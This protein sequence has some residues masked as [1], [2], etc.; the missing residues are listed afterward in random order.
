MKPKFIT[1][2]LSVAIMI[3]LSMTLPKVIAQHR[4]PPKEA[5]EACIGKREGDPCQFEAPQGTVYGTCR[6]LNGRLTCMPDR[7]PGQRRDSGN[8]PGRGKMQERF[9]GIPQEQR[10]D[11][12]ATTSTVGSICRNP[13]PAVSNIVDTGQNRC[14][15][16]KGGTPCQ[17]EGDDFYG[18]D[19]HYQGLQPSY[20][21]SGNSTVIDI[22]TGLTWQKTPDFVK[23]TM[24][25]AENYAESLALAG[26]DDWRL[27]TIKELFSIA[28]FRGNMKTMTP[29]IN[30]DYFDFTYPN[31]D[32]GWRIIDAQYRSSNRY[33]GITMR[34]DS[35]AFGFNFADGRI[36]AILF[37]E[38]AELAVSMCAVYVVRPTV[39]TILL[40][41]ETVRSQTVL[42]V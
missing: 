27:P 26:Y 16:N 15:G 31:T 23:R 1:T 37:Q 3:C 33:V 32:E 17:K 30:T 9:R 20:K 8:E 29:Y 24:S 12:R 40:T 21:D 18:Q 41:M 10:G 6:I 36:K 13:K 22:N 5:I 7:G 38:V 14:Y 4:K 42:P 11:E 39:I 25:E 34:G 28:D 2:G 19:A 35:S